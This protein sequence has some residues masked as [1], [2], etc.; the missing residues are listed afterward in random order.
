MYYAL[1][2]YYVHYPNNEVYIRQYVICSEKKFTLSKLKEN[3]MAR[4]ITGV[5]TPSIYPDFCQINDIPPYLDTTDAFN[6]D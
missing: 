2:T 6:I 1:V 4:K 5:T 3:K